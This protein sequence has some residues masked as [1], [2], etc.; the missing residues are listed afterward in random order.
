[1]PVAQA[2]RDNRRCV[3]CGGTFVKEPGHARSKTDDHVFPSSWFPDSTPETVQRWTVPSHLECNNKIGSLEKDLFIR[4]SFCTDPRKIEASGLSK[5]ALAA[6]GIGV[7][8][9]SPREERHRLAL[10]SK[11]LKQINPTWKS[12]VLLP[13]LGAHPGFPEEL[14]ASIEIP[15]D[16]LLA[17]AKKIVRGCEYKMNNERIID[18]PYELS[19]FFVEEEE[20]P[21]V[22]KALAPLGPVNLGPG[23]RI[24]RGGAI[25]DPSVALYRISIWDKLK[26]FAAILPQE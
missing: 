19:I 5:K 4:L 20:V 12:E 17:V 7:S 24:Q 23:F 8:G 2:S 18:P 25:E 6:L 9:L 16:T 15:H 26:F 22:L 13:G 10:K 11:L 14:Q 21:D 1:M 3:H